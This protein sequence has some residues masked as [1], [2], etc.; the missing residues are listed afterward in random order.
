VHTSLP[1]SR[2]RLN[3]TESER[4]KHETTARQRTSAIVPPKL[5]SVVVAIPAAR[6]SDYAAAALSSTFYLALDPGT[7][8]A[9]A[10]P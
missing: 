3:C 1:R 10:V 8:A 2:R 4:S 5:A 7:P 9:S 6:V